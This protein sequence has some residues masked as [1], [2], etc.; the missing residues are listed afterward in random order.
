[1]IRR[2]L[3]ILAL[4]L[5][6]APLTAQQ[7]APS[8]TQRFASLPAWTGIWEGEVASEMRTDEFG[9]VLHEATTHPESIP[10]VAPPGVLSPSE[11]FMVSRTQLQHKPP[12]NSEWDRKYEQR[13]RKI[14]TTPLSAVRAGSI[15]AC[16][17]DFPAILDNPFDTLFQIFVTPE[18]TLMLFANGQARHLYTDRPHP[19]PEDLWPTDLGN[20]VGHWEAD[21]LVV[22][23][24]SHRGGPFIQIPFILSP[25]LSERAHFIERLRMTDADTLQ[26]DMTI[27]D[28]E[29][30]VR[31][32]TLSLKFRRVKDLDRLIPTNC[33]EN[34]RFRVVNGHVS[35]APH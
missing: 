21:V 28:P 12:Y 31:P 33:T 34:N 13:K 35:I 25:D 5:A 7:S 29:R 8:R 10:V 17:W 32:W 11:A 18:E 16:G 9:A 15:M 1:M 2:A 23:T 14:Q 30:L 19:K 6:W 22:D 26:D 24:I 3:P 27:E 20:S 4:L